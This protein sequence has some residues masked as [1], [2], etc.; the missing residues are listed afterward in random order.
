MNKQIIKLSVAFHLSVMKR[1][2]MNTALRSRARLGMKRISGGHLALR[3]CGSLSVKRWSAQ[4]RLTVNVGKTKCMV[5]SPRAAS[6]P[7][8]LQLRLHS[9]SVFRR[10]KVFS[11]KRA[12][13]MIC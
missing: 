12:G 1:S 9:Q 7:V 11:L 2:C 4:N 8:N 5:G 13:V 6:D 3:E 10:G